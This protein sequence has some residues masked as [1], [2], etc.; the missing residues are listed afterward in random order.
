MTN[1][2]LYPE[3]QAKT[4]QDQKFEYLEIE[5]ADNVL[6]LTLN[7]PE[8]KNA[9]NPQFMNEIVFALSYAHYEQ[10]VWAVQ[11][12]ANGDV[13]TAGA[14]LKAFAGE[15]QDPGRSTIP[16]PPDQVKLGEAFNRL[17]K[18][19]VAK[20]EGHVYAGGFLIICGCTHVIAADHT[21][22]GLPE[23]KRG[24]WPMQ[25]MASMLQVMHSRQVLDFCM[26]GRTVKAQ[27][28]LGLGL[29]TE[30]APGD[31][32]DS[33]VVKLLDDLRQN[34]PSAIRLG[35]KAFYELRHV[36]QN[37]QHAFLRKMLDEI[38]K[39]E[40]AAEGIAAFREKRQPV[41]KGE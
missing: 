31:Q 36:P 5:E 28:A 20:V 35:L 15:Q 2:M 19:T 6:T 17:H 13:Y 10:S 11:V 18:P 4:F 24:I 12:Q 21:K 3:E 29:V 16:E 39:T 25:V 32:I 37:E 14:D 34:S 23:V 22:F 26:R 38:L 33:S 7:R 30:V 9:M 8:K 27:Q 41:W 40:D 1:D